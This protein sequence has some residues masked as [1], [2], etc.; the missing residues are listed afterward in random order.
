MAQRESYSDSYG[1]VGYDIAIEPQNGAPQAQAA[2]QRAGNG[3]GSDDRS[4]RIE[5][6]HSQEMAIRYAA[7]KKLDALDTDGLRTLIDWFQRD[8]GRMPAAPQ[9][10]A[11][12]PPEPESPEPDIDHAEEEF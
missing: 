1:N 4:N 2:P 9:A 12:L 11:D 10:K 7:L 3:G 5:R 8:V 6:Q